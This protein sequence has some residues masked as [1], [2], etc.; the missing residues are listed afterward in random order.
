MRTLSNWYDIPYDASYLWRSTLV[1]ACLS[2]LWTVIALFITY[3]ATSKKSQLWWYIGFLLILIVIAKLFFVDLANTN[4]F[5]RV[6]T[7]M[8][9]GALLLFMG[10]LAPLPPKDGQ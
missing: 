6:I 4:L 10:Y 5:E 2:V 3:Y 8:V 9:V 1:Q 7:F